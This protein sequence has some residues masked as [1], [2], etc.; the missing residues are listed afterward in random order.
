MK[1]KNIFSLFGIS[2]ILLGASIFLNISHIVITNESIVLVF[3]GILATFIV[4]SNYAQVIDIRDNTNK[5]IKELESRTQKKIDDLNKLYNEMNEASNRIK[6]IE[7]DMDFNAAEAYRLYGIFCYDK[8][9]YKNSCKYLLDAVSLYSK[10]SED[11]DSNTILDLVLEML[12]PNNW[13][14][15]SQ[16]EIDFNYEDCLKKVNELPDKY[17][18]KKKIIDSMETFHKNDQKK[19]DN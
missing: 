6:K 7:K 1:Q 16:K 9:L 12:E 13:N 10:N 14:D 18:Q 4:V 15:E 11:D 8:N 5:Q 3:V 2:L 17:N 19:K